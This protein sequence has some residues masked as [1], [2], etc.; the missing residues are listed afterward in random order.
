MCKG[1][2]SFFEPRR[3]NGQRFHRGHPS[4][5]PSMRWPFQRKLPP[6]TP[7]LV[8]LASLGNKVHH[9]PQRVPGCQP[10]DH[11]THN[12][13]FWVVD[14]LS[15]KQTPAGTWSETGR[16]LC[17]RK[18]K[19]HCYCPFSSFN[20][21]LHFSSLR[22]NLKQPYSP[23]LPPHRHHHHRHNKQP[24]FSYHQSFLITVF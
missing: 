24:R 21:L 5:N 7:R 3:Y 18:N 17:L 4:P 19:N 11:Y 15:S 13:R 22:N 8:A 20:H 23:R 14:T 12:L 2:L 9:L 6:S 16:D 1:S 10:R